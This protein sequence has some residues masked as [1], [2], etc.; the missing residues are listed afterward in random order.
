MSSKPILFG[1]DSR[2]TDFAAAPSRK[3]SHCGER[4]TLVPR[5]GRNSGRRPPHTESSLHRGARYLQH[6]LPPG[7]I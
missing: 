4:F 7:G 3:C 1:R 6:T 2:N 5:R